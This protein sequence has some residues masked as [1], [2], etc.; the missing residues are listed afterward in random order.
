MQ[1]QIREYNEEFEKEYIQVHNRG[2][3]GPDTPYSNKIECYNRENNILQT[4]VAIYKSKIVGIIDIVEVEETSNVVEIDP[5]GVLPQF[6]GRGI[7]SQLLD[8]CLEWASKANYSVVRALVSAGADKKLIKFFQRKGFHKKAQLIASRDGDILELDP[9]ETVP[10]PHS[11]I[12][13]HVYIYT[14]KIDS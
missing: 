10:I 13:G 7:G 3:A 1:V 4:F 9:N 12:R 11:S 6:R 14:I 8:K 5:I 2:F